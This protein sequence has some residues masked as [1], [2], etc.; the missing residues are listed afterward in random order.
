MGRPELAEQYPTSAV[1]VENRDYINSVVAE[2]MGKRSLQEV[3]EGHRQVVGQEPRI[4][5]ACW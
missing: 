3:I 2:W 1:R 4:G 5:R